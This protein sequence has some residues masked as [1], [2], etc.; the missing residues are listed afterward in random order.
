MIVA[1]EAVGDVNG[2]PWLRALVPM[3]LNG[4]RT[5]AEHR[6]I[7]EWLRSTPTQS[8]SSSTRPRVVNN[9]NYPNGN[10]YASLAEDPDFEQ[11]ELVVATGSLGKATVLASSGGTPLIVSSRAGR[12]TVTVLLFDPERDPGRSWKN[13]PSLWARLAGVPPELY[14]NDNVYSRSSSSIDGVFGAMVDSKQIRKLPVE[15]LLLLLIV[16]LAVIGP[17]DQYWLKRI[18][19]PMLT[20]LTFPCYVV[21]FSMMIYLIGYKLRAG[22]TEWNE[23]HLVDVLPRNDTFEMRGRSYFSIYSPVNETYHVESQQAFSAFRGESM[24]SYGVNTGDERAEVFQDGENY[25][26]N[27]F[28]PVWTSQLYASDWWSGG[29]GAEGERDSQQPGLAGDDRQPSAAAAG[30]R[31]P[32]NFRDAL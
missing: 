13:L 32:G 26:A 22:E 11:A 4:T 7:Q 15:W 16:Y 27:I 6:E 1:V 2:T 28:V 19:R 12:G 24:G 29:P 18:E 21:F 30:H 5:V 14:A 17:L 31:T 3:E 20:W 8:S 25:K 10:P 23:L 9:I